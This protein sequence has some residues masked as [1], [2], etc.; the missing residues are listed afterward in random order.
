MKKLL[1]LTLIILYGATSFG[2]VI[3]LHYCC[4]KLDKVTII[5]NAAASC[6]H[7]TSMKKKSCCNTKQIKIKI[8]ADQDNAFSH[9][10]LNSF[11]SILIHS[12]NYFSQWHIQSIP[13]SQYNTGPLRGLS[14][15]I[16]LTNC[17]FRI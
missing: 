4:G 3:N 12:E 17:V 16:Y 6:K 1:S 7:A 5:D 13:T 15:P 8:T 10:Q 9:F 14:D 11:S 2:M